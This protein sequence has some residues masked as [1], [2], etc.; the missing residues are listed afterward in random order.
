MVAYL[1]TTRKSIPDGVQ[2]E[3]ILTDTICAHW[4]ER[5]TGESETEAGGV[6]LVK[7]LKSRRADL[8]EQENDTA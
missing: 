3:V 1:N 4:K 6:K 7:W 8:T 2:N 5:R